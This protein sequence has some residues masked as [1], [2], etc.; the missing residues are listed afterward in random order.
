VIS[1]K[2]GCCEIGEVRRKIMHPNV[3][4][5]KSSDAAQENKFLLELHSKLLCVI[6][7]QRIEFIR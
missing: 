2:A 3:V 7:S 1:I 5:T 4:N 6:R